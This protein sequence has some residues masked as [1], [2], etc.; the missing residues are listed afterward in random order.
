LT[1]KQ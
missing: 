1:P